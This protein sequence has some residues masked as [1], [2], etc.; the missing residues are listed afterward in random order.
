MRFHAAEKYRAY[1]G[2]YPVVDI[3]V[4]DVVATTRTRD[5]VL[6]LRVRLQ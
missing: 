3:F 5:K 6:V 1:S 4:H 2:A